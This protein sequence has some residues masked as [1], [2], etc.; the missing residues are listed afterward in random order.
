MKITK[1][2]LN[3]FLPSLKLASS[4]LK[5]SARRMFL[6]QLA[7][8]YG[9]GGR[10][11]I[12]KALGIS[13]VTLNKG[14]EEVITGIAIKDKFEERGRKKLEELQPQL[15]EDLKKIG[16]TSSQTDPQFKSTRLY[17]RLSI[18]QVRKELLKRGYEEAELPSNETLRNQMMNLGFKRKKVAKTKP[19]KK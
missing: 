9:K 2:N 16:D 6:G 10:V 8:D 13:R 4:K 3:I 12:S 18:N 19:K 7:L 1:E 15:I 11:R 5:G 17:S 14:I